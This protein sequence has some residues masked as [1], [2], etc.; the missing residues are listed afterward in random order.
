MIDI[1]GLS[2]VVGEV[3]G[4]GVVGGEEVGVAGGVGLISCAVGVVGVVSRYGS[5]D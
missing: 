2:E 3:E 4:A 5:D 1:S